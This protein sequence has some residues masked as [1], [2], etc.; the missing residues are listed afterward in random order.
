M[1]VDVGRARDFVSTALSEVG[2]TAKGLDMKAYMKTDMPFYGVQK[3]GRAVILS[4][5]VSQCRPSDRAE[6]ED[7]VLGIWGLP[8]REE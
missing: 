1:S 7:L 8:H 2:D 4:Q 3:G 6:Y 5:L